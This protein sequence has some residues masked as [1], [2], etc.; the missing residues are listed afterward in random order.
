MFAVE[1]V[2]TPHAVVPALIQLV[3]SQRGGKPTIRRRAASIVA[4]VRVSAGAL[5][6]A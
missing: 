5:R 2:H 3:V 1:Q 4:C 6:C